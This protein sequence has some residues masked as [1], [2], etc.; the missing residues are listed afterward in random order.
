[1]TT[2]GLSPRIAAARNGAPALVALTP[3]EV[4]RI[5]RQPSRVIG[6]IGAPLLLWV[7]L[8]GGFAGS[9]SVPGAEPGDAASYG[10]WLLPGMVTLV[11][12]FSA[13]FSAMSLI[14]D[15]NAGF[16]QAA[17]VSPAPRWSIVGSKI[18]G[19]TIVAAA[20]GFLLLLSAPLL[21]PG[22]HPLGWALALVAA[23]LGA[24][25]I[26]AM[27]L[28]LAWWVNS[29]QGFHGIMNL[30]L[31]PMWLLSGA[32]FPAEGASR[33]LAGLMLVNPLRWTT[34]AI[35][36]SLA[37]DPFGAAWALNAAFCLG[38]IALAWLAMTANDG[39]RHD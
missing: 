37:G 26:T 15:R 30:V 36:T 23:A 1:M 10:A 20:Q 28:A 13:I 14:E 4:V 34:D 2:T 3:R 25:A 39:A 29:S 6:T 33:W 22:P 32:F 35:R 27:G 24:A 17:I 7:F 38:A 18:A 9:F 16:L 5:L 19:G 31:M 11:V 8:A 12:M 21:G